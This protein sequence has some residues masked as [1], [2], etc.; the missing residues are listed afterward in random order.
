MLVERGAITRS[1]DRWVVSD[2]GFLEIVPAS[3]RLLIA[4]RLDGLSRAEKRVL[5][6]A[7]VAGTVTWSGLVEELVRSRQT[8]DAGGVGVA[9]R[10]LED[11]DLLRVRPESSVPGTVELEFKHVVIRDVAYESL[12]RSARA[13]AHLVAARWIGEHIGDSA[14]AALAH[15]YERAWELSRSKARS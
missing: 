10:A 6:E 2:P 5:Q 3:L 15:H 14:V 1:R 8:R 13:A 12:P 9:L 7:S 4:A 11:R